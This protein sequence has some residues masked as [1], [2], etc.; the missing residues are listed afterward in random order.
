MW[1]DIMFNSINI[2]SE[3]RIVRLGEGETLINE[4]YQDDL[5][6]LIEMIDDKYPGI[7]IWFKKKVVPGL[8]E[9][10][11]F[12][13]IVYV[14]G[15]P[16]GSAIA[17]KAGDTKLCSMRILPKYQERGIGSLL[18]SLIG[19]EIRNYAGKLHF[20]APLSMYQDNTSFFD[21]LGFKCLGEAHRQYRLF[22]K[23][24]FCTVDSKLLWR[25]VL[26]NLEN[27]I[28]QFTLV[29]NPSH[30]D[31]V[32]SI[33]P[34]YASM[35]KENKKKV[36]IRRKFA[37][38]W[39]GAYA[40]LYASAPVQEFFG[41]AKIA[42][43]IEEKPEEIWKLFGPDMGSDKDAFYEYCE[44]TDRVSALVLSDIDIYKAGIFKDQVEFLLGKELK[45]PQSHC[46]LEDDTIW[47]TAVLLNYL[48]LA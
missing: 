6:Q 4:M 46:A 18:M 20:T 37:K 17:K 35:I 34:E 41:E 13:Y 22:D 14:E 43:V 19:R 16:I 12:A 8:K 1:R 11:R 39:K 29:G 30:P 2:N 5:K 45:A 32:I 25:N 9:K 7:D 47:P 3:V 38:K 31:L 15:K 24:I 48:L 26:R 27:T 10:H 36:E 40:L 33:R 28:Q 23:E 44:G 42:D 21:K